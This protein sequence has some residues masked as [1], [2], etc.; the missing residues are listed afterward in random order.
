M[1]ELAKA[2]DLDR[3]MEIWLRTNV[4]AHHFI[5]ESVWEAAFEEVRAAMPEAKLFV[6]RT[7]TQV[8]GFIGITESKY[9][10]G[11]FVDEK[12]QGQGTGAKLLRYCKQLYPQL[13][14]DVFSANT[15]A[16]RFYKHNCFKIVATKIAPEFNCEEHHM[17]WVAGA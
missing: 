3:I 13:E 9:I 15:N 14:L 8:Q 2:Q 6:Y 17:L 7:A 12:A 10:A 5:P 4:S 16:V 1:I 11:L